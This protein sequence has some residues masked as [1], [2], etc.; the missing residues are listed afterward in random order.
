MNPDHRHGGRKVGIEPLTFI[1]ERCHKPITDREQNGNNPLHYCQHCK[2][3]IQREVNHKKYRRHH[4]RK[5]T[6]Q[7]LLINRLSQSPATTTELLKVANIKKRKTLKANIHILRKKGYNIESK[8]LMP[9]HY[10]LETRKWI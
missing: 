8:H 9:S 10:V 4:R 5:I 2:I 3:E 1:C 6:K 7:E